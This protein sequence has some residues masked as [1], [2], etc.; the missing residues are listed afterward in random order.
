MESNSDED[1]KA[2]DSSVLS[3]IRELNQ[4]SLMNLDS[5]Q[6]DSASFIRHMNFLD[7]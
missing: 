3:N 4:S 6:N 2:D 1:S 7:Q 5:S